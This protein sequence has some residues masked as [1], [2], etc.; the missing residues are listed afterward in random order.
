MEIRKTQYHEEFGTNN[1][2]F[3]KVMMREGEM[4]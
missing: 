4:A 2:G 3:C 1:G